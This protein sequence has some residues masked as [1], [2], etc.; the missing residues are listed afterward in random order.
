[1]VRPDHIVALLIVAQ[2]KISLI[3]GGLSPII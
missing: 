2:A 3:V 1:M